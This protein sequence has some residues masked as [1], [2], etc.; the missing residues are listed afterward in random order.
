MK[1]RQ[2][3][4]FNPENGGDMFLRKVGTL[5]QTTC[6]HIPEDTTIHSLGCEDHTYKPESLITCD[7]PK[8]LYR[9]PWTAHLKA[10]FNKKADLYLSQWD[11]T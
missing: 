7:T 4:L 11:S 3:A 2:Q 10:S 8:T 9:I 5:H 1:S 6:R